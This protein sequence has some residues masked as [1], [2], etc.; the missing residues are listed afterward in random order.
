MKIRTTLYTIGLTCAAGA[1]AQV[2]APPP[3][4]YSQPSLTAVPGANVTPGVQTVAP[5]AGRSAETGLPDWLEWGPVLVRPHFLERI[6]YSDGLLA[7]AGRPVESWIEEFS[8]GVLFQLGKHWSL[9]YTPTLRFYSAPSYKNTTDHAVMLNGGT[10]YQDWSFGLSQGYASSSQPLIETARQT[11]TES[12]NTGLSAAWQMSSKTS[13]ELSL[14]Q[15]FQ[16][17]GGNAASYAVSDSRT[18]QTMDW[19]NYQFNPKLSAGVGAGGGYTDMSRGTDMTFEQLQARV[20]WLAARKL[21]FTVSFGGEYRQF[22]DTPTPN[23]LTPIFSLSTAYQVFEQTTLSLTASRSTSPSL[24]T[25]QI[26]E[27]T[28]FTAGLRQRL[29]ERLFLDLTAGYSTTEYQLPVG[30]LVTTRE[31]DRTTVGARLSCPFLKRATASLFY[32]WS[33]NPSSVSGFDYTSNQGGLELAYR[34]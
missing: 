28:G 22:L 2:L 17:V 8:P 30:A 5:P 3:A 19:V 6:S 29:L 15:N 32:Y 4:D 20:S 1:N 18:W 21:S 13:L 12:F 9:D 25:G 16:L 24:L 11:D 31:D 34:F 27:S 10:T 23:S 26:Q 33:H 14:S 7:G